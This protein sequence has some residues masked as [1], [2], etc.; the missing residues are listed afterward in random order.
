MF[1]SAFDIFRIGPG[2]SS[3]HTVAPMRAARRF[4]HAL[5][6]DGLF[7]QTRR[8]QTDLYGS[9][10]CAGRD[11]ATDRAIIGGLC[12]DAPETVDAASLGALASRVRADGSLPLGRHSRIRFEPDDV[13]FHV[14][15]AFAY[16]SNAIRFTARNSRG[17]TLASRLYFSSGDGDIVADG[18]PGD[19]RTGVRVPYPFAS[20][21]ELLAIARKHGKKIADVMRTNEL[22]LRSPGEVHGA[23]VR[24]ASAMHASIERGLAADGMLPG[25]LGLPRRAAVRAESLAGTDI[26]SPA[27]AAAFATAASEHNAA[28]GTVV[29]APSNGAAGPVAALL[30][31]WRATRPLHEE[32][33]AVE[34]LLAAA[35]V[36]HLLRASG[37]RHAGCQSQVGVAS[38]MAAAGLVTVLGGTNGQVLFAVERALEPHLSL[39]CDPV[40]GLIQQ[41]CIERNARGAAIAAEASRVALRQTEPIH[42]SLDPLLRSM[43]ESARAM[44]GRYKE[45]SLGGVALSVGDC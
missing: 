42:L 38:A 11:Q 17:E 13:L 30:E 19:A 15:K 32:D 24:V 4:V 7:F 40:G 22:A 8:V 33:G 45:S 2:P 34:F 14:D 12:G 29:A 21:G 20:A 3:T 6:A 37:L 39:T 41:P 35:A 9:I 16:H 43:I 25:H 18:D 10:A 27:W 26:R 23:L 31:Q 36:C 28:G 5:E 1:I 44:A